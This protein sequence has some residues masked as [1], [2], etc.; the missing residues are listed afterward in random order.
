M[1]QFYEGWHEYLLTENQDN[2]NRPTLSDDLDMDR[3]NSF[4]SVGF[5]HHHEILIRTDTLEERFFYIGKCAAEFWDYRL[6]K[7]N[8]TT[9][10]FAEQGKQPNNFSITI[11]DA[12]L[13]RKALL[14]F[15]DE[16]LLE[17]GRAHV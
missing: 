6:L 15:K 1:R 14:S 9:K 2:I 3:W 4:L 11:S 13:R 16:Y 7:H 17:I 5:S 8:L 12:D 10:L